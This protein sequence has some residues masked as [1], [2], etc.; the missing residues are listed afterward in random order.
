[1]KLRSKALAG[2]AM[3]LIA[4]MAC[5]GEWNPVRG[6][7]VSPG[8][9]SHRIIV[10]FQGTAAN[11]RQVQLVGRRGRP[12]ATLDRIETTRAD[13]AALAARRGLALQGSRQIS[14]AM[15][16]LF[17]PDTLYGVHLEALLE[18]LRADPAISF[19]AIDELR[20]PLA[21]PQ[22][23][24]PLFPPTPG[25]ASGQWYLGAPN[26]AAIADG[27]LTEDLA[28]TDAVDAWGLTTG[29]AGIVIA[30]V[31][32]GV[33]FSHPDLLRA[34]LGGRLLPGYDF[35]GEDL[36]ASDSVPLGTYLHA[37]D[38][39]GWDPDPT[40]PG[41]WI[42]S[43]DVLNPL[44]PTST[45][46]DPAQYGGLI[47]SSWHG[48]RVVGLFGA[49]T[50]NEVGIAGL[51]WGSAA[52]PGP[53]ILPVRALGKCGGYD[54]DIIA[55]IEWAVGLPVTPDSS[56][57][58][59]TS[60]VPLNPFPADIVNLSLGG[61]G[62]CSAAYLKALAD[63]TSAGALVVISAGNGGQ[64]G[65]LAPVEAPANCSLQVGGVIAVAGLRNV[66]T[67]V[68]YSS[69]GPEV[70]IGAPAG[71]C[72]NSSGACLRSI[73]T[74]T[75]SGT[76]TASL[77]GN[78]YTNE[79]DP[80]LGTSFAAPIVAGVAALMRSVNANLTPA[81]LVARLQSGAT[82]FPANSGGVPVCPAT[83]PATGECSCPQA[84]S[85]VPTQCG[86]GMVNALQ[87]VTAA[88][89]PIAVVVT[90]AAP[91]AGTV[92]FDASASV[93]ACGNT[94]GAYAWRATPSALITA[95]AASARVSLN[96][97]VLAAGTT[98]TLVLT[99]TDAA[100]H[101]DSETL[102]LSPDALLSS[103]AATS[104]GSAAAA[105]PAMLAVNPAAPAAP[106]VNGIFS[107]AG[108]A[109]N[110][111]ATLTLTLANANGYALPGTGLA[112]TLPAGLTL[113][114]GAQATTTCGG[115][116]SAV[117]A[118]Q[119]VLALTNAIIPAAGSCSVQLSLQAA[120]VG[121]YAV[122]IPAGALSS[123]PAGSSIQPATA[124]LTVAA[125]AK[126]GGGALRFGEIM[127]AAAWLWL[128]RRRKQQPQ[129]PS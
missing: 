62:S 3:A 91:Y 1:M 41:D 108:V 44:F 47:P 12:A 38:G 33:L 119:G 105:C 2:A 58:S 74:T 60:P 101:A 120:A 21:A 13:V 34:N 113:P 100:G 68:G 69:F 87:A 92:V 31:D 89:A 121:S 23:G 19:A 7:P 106:T 10:G 27:V 51:T 116:A 88:L 128:K 93:A 59:S 129:E 71:N 98:G 6:A 18:G 72:I 94:V 77:S 81:Q 42:S 103:T 70:G 50:N 55:G 109:P 122:A 127:A 57:G 76:T 82:P 99:V 39:D 80:N 102:V 32:T 104:A 14:G 26:P 9:E 75:N 5:A 25:I 107:P 73:D 40:D 11:T 24:D 110:S 49:L 22:P 17:L 66:G 54:S 48:T 83:D 29:S 95:G 84:G 85:G 61:T 30:D 20:H 15:H 124:T 90:P 43:A 86:T 96:P 37:N 36:N 46:G 63:A 117:S 35:V 67:K 114:A 112:V 79:A 97:A 125:P 8:L 65:Q 118:T 52:A 4:A 115:I 123:G 53:W 45:C 111:P 16:V 64:P 78:T 56:S 126:G 28:A